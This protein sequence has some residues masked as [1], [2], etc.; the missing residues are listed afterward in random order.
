MMV[1]ERAA[2]DSSFRA[3]LRPDGDAQAQAALL[4]LESLIHS[5]LDNGSLTKAQAV[6]AIENAL[7]VK[8]DSLGE[9]K[10]PG[11]TAH[12]SLGLLIRL[13]ESIRAHSGRYDPIP[14]VG[15]ETAGE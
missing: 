14:D 9:A 1:N 8:E 13:Q 10:E 4:L 15:R 3:D 6:D 5:L 2:A 7:Q 12:K 11:D